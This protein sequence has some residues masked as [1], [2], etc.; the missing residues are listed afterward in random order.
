MDQLRQVIVFGGVK[1]VVKNSWWCKGDDKGE[2]KKM[3]E[4]EKE[5]DMTCIFNM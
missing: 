1:C 5:K 3:G 4:D 2:M